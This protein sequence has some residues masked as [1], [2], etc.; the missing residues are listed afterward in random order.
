VPQG[1]ITT[2]SKN[3]AAARR[4]AIGPEIHPTNQI[5]A[6]NNTTAI[7]VRSARLEITPHYRASSTSLASLHQ[8][9]DSQRLQ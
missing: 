4:Q 8:T 7:S 9:D 6:P 2:S 3:M 1:K 5:L